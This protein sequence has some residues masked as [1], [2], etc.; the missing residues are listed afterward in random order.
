MFWSEKRRRS[1]CFTTE[2]VWTMT[3]YQSQVDMS[4]Y[5]LD[6]ALKFDLTRHLNGQPLQ[7][8]MKDRYS[9]LLIKLPPGMQRPNLV[10]CCSL[11][12]CYG[13]L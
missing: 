1:L 4:T 7:F 5:E 12:R 8:M 13:G 9:F 11:G 6:V 3:L 10:C 2:H